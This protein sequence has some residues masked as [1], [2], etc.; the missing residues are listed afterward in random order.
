M[1]AEG[2]YFECSSTS[3]VAE[4]VFLHRIIIFANGELPDPE[5]ARLLLRPDD[6]IICADGGTRLALGLGV[7]P[8]LI[9]GDMDS[10]EKAQ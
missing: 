8:N 7:Q 2:T 1:L 9:I 10:A 4:D 6:T 5:K 3:Y